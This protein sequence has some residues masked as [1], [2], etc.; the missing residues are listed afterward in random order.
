MKALQNSRWAIALIIAALSVG[1][2][3]LFRPLPAPAQNAEKNAQAGVSAPEGIQSLIVAG[4]FLVR[5]KR[6]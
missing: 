6:F 3:A 2:W 1:A 4:V 5:G